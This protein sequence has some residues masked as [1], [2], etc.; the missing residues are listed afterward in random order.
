M[1]NITVLG[2]GAS[3]GVPII[4][5]DCDICQSDNPKNKRS[6]ASILIESKNTAVIVDLSPDFRSQMLAHNI[7]HIDAIFLTHAHADHVHGIDD[8]RPFNYRKQG[9][10]PIYSDKSTLDEVISRFSYAFQ[11]PNPEYGWFRPALE[12]IAIDEHIGKPYKI[13][14]EITIIPFYLDHGSCMTLGLRI[15]DVVYSTDVKD[16]PESAEPFLQDINTWIVDCLRPEPAPT[17]AHLDMTLE[18]IEQYKPK[19]AILTHMSHAFDYDDLNRKCPE[20]VTPA[21]DGLRITA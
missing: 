11:K 14:D 9:V 16:F 2:C 5:C 13:T 21:Y 15:N 10:L 1:I 7:K 19:R 4:G 17:H 20:H 8:V 18:W 6:R 3:A 12:A